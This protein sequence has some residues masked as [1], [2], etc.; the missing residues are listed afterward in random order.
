[1]N[2]HLESRFL[3][4]LL[5]AMGP[6][7]LSGGAGSSSAAYAARAKYNFNI[8][9]RFHLNTP[10]GDPTSAGFND[11]NWETVSVPHN[12]ENFPLFIDP[13]PDDSH[14]KKFLRKIGWYRKHFTVPQSR[15][16]KVF[17]E[18]E[19]VGQ[20]TDA[21]VNGKHVGQHAIGGYTAFHFDITEYVSD[22]GTD[23]VVAVKA[24]FTHNDNIP[25]DNGRHDYL[26]CGG[27]YRDVYLVVTDKLHVTFPFEGKDQG[28]FI[29]TPEASASSAT[30]QMQT[31]V[32]NEY[33]VDKAT[34]LT[35]FILDDAGKVL[36]TAA[37]TATIPAGEDHVF[38][39]SKAIANPH[40]WSCDDPYLHKIRTVV[41]EGATITDV[42]EDEHF[43]I[44]WFEKS[45]DYGLK[46]NGKVVELI[47][48]N[49]HQHVPYVG[50]A[51]P[52]AIHFKDILQLKEAGMNFVRLCHYP[53]DVATL[54]ACDRLGLLALPEPPTWIDEPDN[55]KWKENLALSQRRMIRVQRNCPSAFM[56]AAGI[57]HLGYREYL[58]E[59][60][61]DEDPTR[62]THNDTTTW[63]LKEA[64]YEKVM[65]KCDVYSTM[66]YGGPKIPDYQRTQI[67]MEHSRRKDLVLDSINS[68][69]N[70]G[71]A[72]WVAHDYFSFKNKNIFHGPR[73]I[74][75][76]RVPYVEGLY[77]W[78]QELLTGKSQAKPMLTP[79]STLEVNFD[80]DQ[81]S[82]V[83]DGADW[84]FVYVK[85]ATDDV[86]LSL[87]GPGRIIGDGEDIDANPVK[88]DSRTKIATFLIQ[89]TTTP[90]QIV[91]TASSGGSTASASV[92]SVEPK[93]ILFQS[94]AVSIQP[95]LQPPSLNPVVKY[96]N[97]G[98]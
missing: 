25:P 71:M 94:D 64:G 20:V 15:G 68:P 74:S 97:D 58:W 3:A 89:T 2:Q 16:A 61:N 52:D 51:A 84:V 31:T 37:S 75:L 50:F 87:S 1:M 17:L 11:G 6:A 33:A 26:L 72:V 82:L 9:W 12:L 83:A 23:N 27:I 67:I 63:K 36:A 70:F 19:G 18:F 49:M 65:G 55:Q 66:F 29:T 73:L 76:F 93:L 78:Y 98:L 42:H 54:K 62:W 43:G 38:T 91:A 34:T 60:A 41:S 53:H 77:Y 69:N 44:R 92:T 80:M 24:D 28:I 4:I 39:H 96:S 47:G 30:V 14:Q 57:N 88:V 32:R 86:T 45:P 95:D 85:G 79:S 48:A 40:L 21:W 46:M 56:W 81:R 35:S 10:S 8:G 22:G 7:F 13:N 59:A 90:G 5:M